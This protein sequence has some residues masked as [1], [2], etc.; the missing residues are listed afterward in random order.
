MSY[1][2][3]MEPEIER[4]AT[5]YAAKRGM[6]LQGF[7]NAYL[8]M[9]VKRENAHSHS[10]SSGRRQISDKVHALRGAAKL[11]DMRPYKDIIGDAILEKY[12][13]LG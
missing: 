1:T 5:A 8:V 6:T 7:I 9:I 12:E 2:M 4:E 10:R 3:T 11:D 13:A